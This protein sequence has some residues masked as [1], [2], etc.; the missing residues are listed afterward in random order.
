MSEA[1][2]VAQA[3]EVGPAT[4]LVALYADGSDE[5]VVAAGKLS[6]EMIA[7]TATW[8]D[9]KAHPQGPVVAEKVRSWWLKR[10]RI[11]ADGE[12]AEELEQRWAIAFEKAKAK[13][14]P[15]E[16]KDEAEPEPKPKAADAE[17]VAAPAVVTKP[18]LSPFLPGFEKLPEPPKPPPGAT[19]L[20]R[21][22]YPPGLLGHAT[23]HAFHCTDLPDRQLALWGAKAGLGKILDRKLITP[24]NG[25]TTSYDLLLADTGAGKEDAQQFALRL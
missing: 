21:L 9:G 12:D 14:P 23:D 15:V 13:P 3:A 24:K 8:L 19:D 18:A 10:V 2:K 11:G 16:P 1:A 20:E 25:S 22:C 4:R 7:E 6:L 17:P 5:A